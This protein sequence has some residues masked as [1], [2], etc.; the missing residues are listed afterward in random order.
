MYSPIIATREKEV[1]TVGPNDALIIRAAVQET[2]GSANDNTLDPSKDAEVTVQVEAGAAAIGSGMAWQ[3]G[4]VVKDLVDGGTIPFVLS[5]TT[6]DSGSLGLAPWTAETETFTYKVPKANLAPAKGH[7][8][9]VYDYLLIGINP[10]H[11]EASF[12]ESPLFLVL[13]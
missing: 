4:V 3:L 8:C 12:V 5:P 7:L 13:P 6:K 1:I 11:Y 9:Q 10:A 2:G